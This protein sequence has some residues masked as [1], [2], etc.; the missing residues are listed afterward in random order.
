[1]PVDDLF[2]MSQTCKMMRDVVTVYWTTAFDL[3]RL[4]RPFIP[5]EQLASFQNMLKTTAGI[6]SGS[7]ALQFLDRTQYQAAD[8]DLYINQSHIDVASKWFLDRGAR[9]LFNHD[10]ARHVVDI[11]EGYHGSG[12]IHH[13]ENFEVIH[14]II[15][16]TIQVI[17]TY[18]D[19]VFAVLKFHSCTY[20]H[21]DGF[22][23]FFIII[24]KLAL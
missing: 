21:D 13:I 6:I 7:T 8:L 2:R 18:G 23:F 9:R 11:S 1:M 4:I 20:A 24:L 10:R 19:P 14:S 16:R 5:G 12:E 3:S 22:S 15:P 17:A